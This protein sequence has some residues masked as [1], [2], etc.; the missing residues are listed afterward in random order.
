MKS[1]TC[2]LASVL[3]AS[4]AAGQSVSPTMSDDLRK[5]QASIVEDG[6]SGSNVML[7]VRDG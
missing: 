5:V 7:V 2:A 6:L 4:S 3:L 1:L